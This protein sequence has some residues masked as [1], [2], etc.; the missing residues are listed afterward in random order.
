MRP[1]HY[2]TEMCSTSASFKYQKCGNVPE[3]KGFTF[4]TQELHF[5]SKTKKKKVQD[6]EK[7]GMEAI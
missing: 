7:E 4:A 2:A 1:R 3:E 6:K 5:K